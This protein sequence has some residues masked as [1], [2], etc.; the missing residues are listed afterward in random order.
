MKIRKI[1]SLTFL[2][3]CICSCSESKDV[4]EV[5]LKGQQIMLSEDG[6]KLSLFVDDYSDGDI[7]REIWEYDL[8]SLK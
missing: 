5:S 2:A 6:K 1:L 3:L 7:R 8:S 4:D